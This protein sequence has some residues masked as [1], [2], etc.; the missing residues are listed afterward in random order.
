MLWNRRLGKNDHNDDESSNADDDAEASLSRS[1]HCGSHVC[2]LFFLL[3][4][5]SLF[6]VSRF[7]SPFLAILLSFCFG[8]PPGLGLPAC[9]SFGIMPCPLRDI[10][11][12]FPCFLWS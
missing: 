5:I 9:S 8:S 2:S 11:F 6:S 12:P 1:T 10:F 4:S 3:Q 7:L